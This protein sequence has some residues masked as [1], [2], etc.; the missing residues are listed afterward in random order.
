V[1]PTKATHRNAS[2]SQGDHLPLRCPAGKLQQHGETPVGKRLHQQWQVETDQSARQIGQILVLHSSQLA[3]LAPQF[4][5]TASGA[6]QWV[7]GFSGLAVPFREAR[8]ASR[9]NVER[10]PVKRRV[11]PQPALR[12]SRQRR[13]GGRIG[14]G[15]ASVATVYRTRLHSMLAGPVTL[16]KRGIATALL[17]AFRELCEL[18]LIS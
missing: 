6:P 1:P 5:Q 13:S 4:R 2:D 12:A 17:T 9:G 11:F 18:R 7:S 15:A 3:H 14:C 8:G 16:E 10:F